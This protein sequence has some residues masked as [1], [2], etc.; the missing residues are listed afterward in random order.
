MA[1]GHQDE[2]SV[3]FR[4]L[5]RHLLHWTEAFQRAWVLQLFQRHPS[6]LGA[7]PFDA[8]ICEVLLLSLTLFLRRRQD[9]LR[10]VLGLA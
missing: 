4:R 7:F 5:Q 6:V 1:R 10:A 9:G 8:D 2:V 3:R